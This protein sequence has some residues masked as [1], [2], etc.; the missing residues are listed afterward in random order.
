MKKNG[1]AI[2]YTI[3]VITIA[4]TLSMNVS[5]IIVKERSL[6]RVARNSIDAR[7]AA[8]MGME[9]MLFRDKMPT[10]FDVVRNPMLF[11]FNC[12]LDRNNNPVN[13]I[14]TLTA[15]T[16]SGFEY[17]VSN[18][19]SVDGACFKAYLNRDLTTAPFSTRIQVYGYNICDITN[20]DR[21]ERGVEANYT[22]LMS[23]G[24]GGAVNTFSFVGSTNAFGNPN[25]VTSG[26]LDT[27]GAN[28]IVIAL[29]SYS[30]VPIPTITDSYSNSWVALN[31]YDGGTPPTARYTLFYSINPIV[32]IGHTF[33]ASSSSGYPAVNV[34]AFSSTG[35]PS[36]DQENG[37]GLSSGTSATVGPITPTNNNSLIITGVNSWQ[38]NASASVNS[39]FT[40]TTSNGYFPSVTFG[41]AAAYLI[42]T[43]LSSVGPTWSFTG[44]TNGTGV[45]IAVFNP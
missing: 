40:L 38:A 13:Y 7:A 42:Q 27:T 36:F 23:G 6:S 28:L 41:S 12:G 22:T 8:D 16:T 39:G 29:A 1:F 20:S 18:N 11:V 9:C 24:G 31:N 35:S 21:V 37:N 19:S 33:T 5:S 4:L 25:N 2:L 44:S 26:S 17:S 14:A 32:G 30:S 43:T 45:G 10:E 15:S 34:L 3:L